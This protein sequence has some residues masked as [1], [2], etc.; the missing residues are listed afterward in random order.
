MSQ[1]W[2]RLDCSCPFFFKRYSTSERWSRDPTYCSY[3]CSY[4]T[5]LFLTHFFIKF[6]SLKSNNICWKLE[7]LQWC[8]RLPVEHITNSGLHRFFLWAIIILKC[9]QRWLCSNKNELIS[10]HLCSSL[11]DKL[12]KPVE[13]S[14]IL[15]HN[16]ENY[17][18]GK[19][20]LDIK[21]YVRLMFNLVLVVLLLLSVVLYY[22]S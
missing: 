3:G 4:F 20:A 17:A 11:S 13:S 14:S 1:L 15:T 2:I 19:H 8:H 12:L 18:F 7:P 21:Y 5:V 22:K 10:I 6:Y 16:T 9:S